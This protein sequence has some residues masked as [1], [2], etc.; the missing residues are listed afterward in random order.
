M[1]F[2]QILSKYKNNVFNTC[3][4][5][6]KNLTEA[7]DLAQEVFI[8]V[9][10]KMDTFRGESA[11]ETWIYRIAVN[12]S[13]DLIRK[14]SRLKRKQAFC[15]TDI[16][17]QEAPDLHHPGVVLEQKER[18]TILFRAIEKLPEKQ[19]VAFT[20]QK[21]EG[22]SAVEIGKIL[23]RSPSSVESLLF[24]ARQNLKKELKTYYEKNELE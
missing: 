6:V 21:L 10:K 16:N 12:K 2:E 19:R 3:I 17:N 4:G 18:A 14:N 20:L 15:N 22:L 11:I 8:E 5:F 13:L 9:Y 1:E 24:R 23:K 7:E